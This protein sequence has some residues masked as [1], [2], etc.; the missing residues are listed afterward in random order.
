MSGTNGVPVLLAGKKTVRE[1]L[2]GVNF[3]ISPLSFYQ[4]N[5]VQTVKLYDKKDGELILVDEIEVGHI[6]CEYGEYN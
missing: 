4:V 3:E 1:V 2:G 5:P 6:G